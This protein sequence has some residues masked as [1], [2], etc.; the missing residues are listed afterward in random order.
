MTASTITAED[1]TNSVAQNIAERL[2]LKRRSIRL[3]F[4]SVELEDFNRLSSYGLK[5]NENIVLL[6]AGSGGGKRA[7]V[8]FKEMQVKS[9][10][11]ALIQSC[12]S[13]GEFHANEWLKSVPD[14]L[15]DDYHSFIDKSAHGHQERM[16]DKTVECIREYIAV[17][18]RAV[19]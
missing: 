12:F 18:D 17:K 2:K 5:D 9:D 4:N 16:V 10:D 7:R 19:K 6:T 14:T 11:P 1:L 15:F 8:S 13:I 3:I